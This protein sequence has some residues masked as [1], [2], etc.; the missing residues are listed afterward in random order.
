ME[1]KITPQY[2]FVQLGKNWI[3]IDLQRI[4]HFES[5]G[6]YVRWYETGNQPNKGP[7]SKITESRLS[8]LSER[9]EPYGF[10][11]VHRRYSVNIRAVEK[12][13]GESLQLESVVIP[14]GRTRRQYVLSRLRSFGLRYDHQSISGPHPIHEIRS[15]RQVTG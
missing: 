11:R 15:S 1:T 9:L 12:F 10:I 4:S 13:D 14:V 5:S 7:T 6:D 2:T 8:Q 3:R